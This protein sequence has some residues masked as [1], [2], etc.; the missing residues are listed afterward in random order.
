M[1]L[2]SPSMRQFSPWIGHPIRLSWD[3]PALPPFLRLISRASTPGWCFHL[4]SVCRLHPL[5]IAFRPRGFSPPRRLSPRRSLG[6]FAARCRKGFAAFP[7]APAPAWPSASSSLANKDPRSGRRS[8]N[9]VPRNA[10]HTLRSIP[11]ASS[12]TASLRPLPSCRF[13]F[14]AASATASRSTPGF[15]SADESVAPATVSGD[16]AP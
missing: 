7:D 4:P 2:A 15:Y 6:H 8:G 16:L 3:S 10:A 12:R 14:A 9:V 1:G 5:H 13:S 11:L